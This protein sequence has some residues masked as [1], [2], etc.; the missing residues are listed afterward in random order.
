MMPPS[1]LKKGGLKGVLLIAPL[2]LFLFC[3][4]VVQPGKGWT[5]E[6]PEAATPY[7]LSVP[8]P[9]QLPDETEN[10]SL[11]L[12][13]LKVVGALGVVIGVMLLVTILIKKTGLARGG[14]SSG[15]LINILETRM[16]APKKYVAVMKIADDFFAVG[17]SD[18]HINMLSRLDNGS[19]K[20]IEASESL[21]NNQS[22]V[23]SSF[24]SMLTKAAR[25]SKRKK[26]MDNGK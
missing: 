8:A 16:V 13:I 17:I 7:S 6:I 9:N 21:R 15:V 20:L 22:P 18:Q 14:L 10:A 2:C 1:A 5:E 24:S 23:S 4:A 3:L 12:A 11:F 26:I 19:S 25:S